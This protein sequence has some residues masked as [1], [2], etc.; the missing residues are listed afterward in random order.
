MGRHGGARVG[1]AEGVKCRGEG[2]GRVP[3]G[4]GWQGLGLY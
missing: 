1:E 2:A 3:G 4:G